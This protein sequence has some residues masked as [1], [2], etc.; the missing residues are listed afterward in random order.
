[1]F[2]V[3]TWP[4]RVGRYSGTDWLVLAGI[5]TFA[6]TLVGFHVWAMAVTGLLIYY[7]PAFL[8]CLA[9]LGM[10]AAVAPR[11][12]RHLHLHHWFSFGLLSLFTPLQNP[13]SA[14]VQAALVGFFVEGVA[15]W[16][17]AELFPLND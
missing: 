6:L 16:G 3:V 8:A 12:G 5:L 7:G 14:I 1:M 2:Y 17:A 9:M 11:F 13:L 4:P 10:G 15:S